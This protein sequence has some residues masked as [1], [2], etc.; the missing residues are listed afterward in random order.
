MNTAHGEEH[1]AQETQSIETRSGRFEVGHV[2]SIC[3]VVVL[4]ACL[5]REVFGSFAGSLVSIIA[6]TLRSI[7]HHGAGWH[8]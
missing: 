1:E 3:L 2:L 8:G 6:D 5:E 4:L 7:F